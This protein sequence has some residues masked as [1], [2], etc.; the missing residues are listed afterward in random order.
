[1]SDRQ[2]FTTSLRA[3]ADFLDAHPEVPCPH[4]IVLN[5]FTDDRPT[6][7][8]VARTGRW[9]KVYNDSWFSLVKSFGEHLTLEV[10]AQRSTV[11][12]QVVV[13]TRIRPA[14]PAEPECEEEVTEWVCD[15]AAL[16]ETADV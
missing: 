15:D 6:L 13:G 8:A 3:L 14:K 7:A 1:M 16:L 5:V 12:R 2:Q 9:E 4:Y 10:N 11:C